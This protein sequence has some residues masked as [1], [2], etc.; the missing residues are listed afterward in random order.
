MVSDIVCGDKERQESDKRGT[1]IDVVIIPCCDFPQNR[2]II[3]YCLQM[4]TTSDN[5]LNHIH[6][7]PC[8]LLFL[9]TLRLASSTSW[10]LLQ[11]PFYHF[12]AI[13]SCHLFLWKKYIL[14]FA[15]RAIVSFGY[16]IGLS[17][18]SMG[19]HWLQDINWHEDSTMGGL[20]H[21]WIQCDEDEA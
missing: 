3:L 2:S 16:N 18:I 14:P 5:F 11:T 17:A 19:V 6:I 9:P 15:C 13:T 21:N 20:D 4:T 8:Y 10:L 12:L 1:V 7:N